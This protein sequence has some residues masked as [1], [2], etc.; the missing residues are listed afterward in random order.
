ME[1]TSKI[2]EVLRNS[3]RMI[4]KSFIMKT[5]EYESILNTNVVEV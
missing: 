3:M 4:G 1:C 2:S 5:T